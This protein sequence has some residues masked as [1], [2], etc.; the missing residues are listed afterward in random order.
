MKLKFNIIFL[1]LFSLPISSFSQDILISQGGSIQTCS[2]TFYDSGGTQVYGPNEDYEITICPEELGQIIQFDFTTFGTQVGA[3]ILTIYNGDNINAQEFG[4]FSGNFSNGPGFISADNPTGCLTFQ[5][6]SNGSAHTT[7]WEA[8]ISCFEP[9]QEIL[10]S[11]DSTNPTTDEEGRVLLCP[12]E[13]VEFFGSAEFS[14]SDQNSIY[15]WDFGDGNSAVGQN[16]TH[17]FNDSG[18]YSVG[19]TVSDDNP[20]GCSS[21]EVNQIVLVAP[22]IDFSGTEASSNEICFGESVNIC[23]EKTFLLLVSFINKMMHPKI[24]I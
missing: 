19:L 18:I 15:N 2:G 9:C 6:T 23:T 1:I 11:I 17:T 12:G 21:I 24:I 14:I 7:G 5:W 13:E 20:E 10:S 3:D 22:A 8:S 16:V 4:T